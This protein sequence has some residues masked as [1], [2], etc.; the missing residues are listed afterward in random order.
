MTEVPAVDPN[1]SFHPPRLHYHV[2]TSSQHIDSSTIAPPWSHTSATPHFQSL[3]ATRET[4]PL[5]PSSQ[6]P[7][8]QTYQSHG[9][10]RNVNIGLD[11]KIY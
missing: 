5:S 1:A 3:S 7:G 6:L 8:R 4:P 9:L 2:Y 11:L 10:L